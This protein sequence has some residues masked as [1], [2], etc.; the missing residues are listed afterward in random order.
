MAMED[1]MQQVEQGIRQHA[2]TLATMDSRTND[3]DRRVQDL[4]RRRRLMLKRSSSINSNIQS[5]TTR[6]NATNSG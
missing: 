4:D 6:S 3:L 1:R 5:S 2:T